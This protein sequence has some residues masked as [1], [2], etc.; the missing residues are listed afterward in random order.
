MCLSVSERRKLHRIDEAVRRSDP[1]LA[2]LIGIFSRLTAGEAM[3][4]HERLRSRHSPIRS[5]LLAATAVI[6]A[7][8]TWLAAMTCRLGTR[9]QP[10]RRAAGRL[11][12]RLPA[13][14]ARRRGQRREVTA[15]PPAHPGLSHP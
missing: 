8:I 4:A 5:S 1:R 9:V 3:P 14:Q 12:R 13:S 15:Q 11:V 10:C 2:S 7:M 6:T